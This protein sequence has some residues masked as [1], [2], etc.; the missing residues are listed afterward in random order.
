MRR[1]AKDEAFLA[2]ALP[3]NCPAILD[4]LARSQEQGLGSDEHHLYS[5]RNIAHSTWQ[6]PFAAMQSP[7]RARVPCTLAVHGIGEMI[8]LSISHIKTAIPY[9]FA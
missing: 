3:S 9:E 2:Q 8:G 7:G 6:V 4:Q 5:S 1:H